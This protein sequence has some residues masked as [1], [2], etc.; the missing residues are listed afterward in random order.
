M[1]HVYGQKLQHRCGSRSH[2]GTADMLHA[3]PHGRCGRHPGTTRDRGPLLGI[4]GPD[5]IRHHTSTSRGGHR[6]IPDGCRGRQ[7]RSVPHPGGLTPGLHRHRYRIVLPGQHIH[8][9][10][11]PLPPGIRSGRD[12][13]HS[14]ITHRQ[15]LL[16]PEEG[17]HART[18]VR[19]DGCGSPHPGGPRGIPGGHELERP[20]P[21][22]SD[23]RTVPDTG[24]PV[25][26]GT[27]A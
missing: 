23:R 9:P 16:G 19:F 2:V 18:P 24:P 22:V 7:I 25:R 27:G 21:G 13:V 20:V 4:C 11:P 14:N 3:D 17:P 6:G 12:R 10:R 1:G 8:D 5:I 26:E 15:L